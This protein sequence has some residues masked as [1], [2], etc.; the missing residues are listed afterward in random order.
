[1]IANAKLYNMPN[2]YAHN[3]A[4]SLEKY[5]NERAYF[6]ASQFAL[7]DLCTEWTRANNTLEA[8]THTHKEPLPPVTPSVKIPA[9]RAKAVATEPATPATPTRAPST[10]ARPVIKLKLGA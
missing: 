1:M 2:S 4:V 3:Q 8:H 5:F 10:S 9:A 7:I 6:F